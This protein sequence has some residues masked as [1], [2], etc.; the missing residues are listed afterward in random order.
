M[1]DNC[2]EM[3]GQED[4]Q[5]REG[6]RKDKYVILGMQDEKPE[7]KWKSRTSMEYWE[8]RIRSKY[9]NVDVGS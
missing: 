4:N 2:E 5:G 3:G 1:K 6:K 8:G 7:R 9:W